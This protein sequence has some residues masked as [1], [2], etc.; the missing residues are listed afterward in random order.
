M[1]FIF[2]LILAALFFGAASSD[3]VRVG[4]AIENTNRNAPYVI[5][6]YFAI[7]SILTLLM[8]TAFAS[9][10]ATRDFTYQTNQI[11][12][13]TPLRKL[14]YLLGRFLGSSAAAL[15]PM[16]GISL[17]IF[18]ASWMPWNEPER[19]G[20][21]LLAPHVWGF[22]VFAI[23]NTLLAAA[24]IFSIAALT[25]SSTIAFISAI[26]LLVGYG[27]AENLI[28]N[29]DNERL[30]MLLDPF[31]VRPFQRLTRYW[32]IAERN[33]LS[34]GLSG[35]LLV[36]RLLWL[37]VAVLVFG[38][39]TWRFSFAERASR[40]SRSGKSNSQIEPEFSS[41]TAQLPAT[42]TADGGAVAWQLI[43]AQCRIDL[44]ETLFSRVFLILL[45]ASII[46]LTA[47]LFSAQRKVMET[48]PY[49]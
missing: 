37:G 5:Q 23:P 2:T 41:A 46:N 20:P 12:F 36:N 31:G 17:G 27:F 8:T 24:I 38:V 34:Q 35:M 39:C 22:L 26:A 7:S 42:E 1:V 47:A 14:P 33:S 48:P 6:T 3:N 30:A 49:L 18:L 25:R 44:K 32:T 4:G 40:K 16:L 28:G 21:N 9:A 11:V 15:F 13:S 43:W 29:L 45:A 10:A 19:W